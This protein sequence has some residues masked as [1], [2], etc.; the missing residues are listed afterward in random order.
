[1]VEYLGAGSEQPLKSDITENGLAVEGGGSIPL[2]LHTAFLLATCQAPHLG[3]INSAQIAT[4]GHA[5]FHWIL[6]ISANYI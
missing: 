6:T 4:I 2:A 3:P 5:I 1:M